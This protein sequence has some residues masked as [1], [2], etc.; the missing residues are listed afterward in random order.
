MSYCKK[1]DIHISN[2]ISYYIVMSRGPSPAQA[3]NFEKG[4]ENWSFNGVNIRGPSRLWFN[5]LEGINSKSSPSSTFKDQA[6]FR[7]VF[8]GLDTSLCIISYCCNIYM[9]NWNLIKLVHFFQNRLPICALRTYSNANRNIYCCWGCSWFFQLQVE[10]LSIHCCEFLGKN[11][12]WCTN[13]MQ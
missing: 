6:W 10:N 2:G 5:F 8:L 9:L 11:I 3:W 4:Q 13:V 1:L 12:L 7:L